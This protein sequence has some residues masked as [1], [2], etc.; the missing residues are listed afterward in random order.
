MTRKTNDTASLFGLACEHSV[1]TFFETLHS[2][3]ARLPVSPLGDVVPISDYV[4]TLF[5]RAII[6][7]DDE[8]LAFLH[9]VVGRL[10]QDSVNK[11]RNS[12]CDQFAT[13]IIGRDDNSHYR[14]V[15]VHRNL[16]R[17]PIG[18]AFGW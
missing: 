7:V 8:R 3:G 10:F 18:T 5:E 17:L 9:R 15:E 14:S 12:L 6:D 1:S 11:P 16:S 2:R 4:D 13:H